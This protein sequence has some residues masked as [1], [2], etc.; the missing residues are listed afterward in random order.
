MHGS[1]VDAEQNYQEAATKISKKVLISN[2]YNII[3]FGFDLQKQR[4]TYIAPQSLKSNT[5]L[6]Q[7]DSL[8]RLS[9]MC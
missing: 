7:N 9:P 2:T 3:S 8:L 4:P 1:D 5:N 6:A